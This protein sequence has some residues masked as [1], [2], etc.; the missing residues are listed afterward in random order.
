MSPRYQWSQCSLLR[1]PWEKRGRR[2]RPQGSR[3]RLITKEI[4]DP[5]ERVRPAP[6]QMWVQM[7]LTAIDLIG[8][9]PPW[10]AGGMRAS[11]LLQVAWENG[12]RNEG[13]GES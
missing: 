6:V 8:V 12:G 5:L 7:C 1:T 11:C 4:P 9:L 13:N 2:L 10:R 3:V